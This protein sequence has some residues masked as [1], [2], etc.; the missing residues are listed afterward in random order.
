MKIKKVFLILAL[1]VSSLFFCCCGKQGNIKTPEDL[2]TSEKIEIA[3][4][5]VGG[6]FGDLEKI[7]GPAPESRHAVRCGTNGE[8]YEYLYEGFSVLTY[9]EGSSERIEEVDK[10]E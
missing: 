6:E 8:D 7:I 10:S 9:K 1:I 3:E 4:K 2:T 5:S